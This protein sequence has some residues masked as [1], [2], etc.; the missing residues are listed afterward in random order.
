[1]F[2]EELAEHFRSTQVDLDG[3][4]LVWCDP[5]AIFSGEIGFLEKV[6]CIEVPSTFEGSSDSEGSTST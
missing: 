1:M 4:G 5:D 6:T 2:I 3:T